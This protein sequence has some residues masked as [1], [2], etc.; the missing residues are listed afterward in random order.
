[1]WGLPWQPLVSRDDDSEELHHHHLSAVLDEG[2]VLPA[3]PE[4]VLKLQNLLSPAGSDPTAEHN[5]VP[6]TG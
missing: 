4:P 3:E 5:P 1:M 2:A 6:F